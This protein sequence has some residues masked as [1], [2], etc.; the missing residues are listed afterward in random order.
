MLWS[1]V[2]IFENMNIESDSEPSFMS[3]RQ[4]LL[5]AI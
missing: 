2:I 3:S 5:E 1:N 4:S